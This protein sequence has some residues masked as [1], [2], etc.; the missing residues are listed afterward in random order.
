MVHGLRGKPALNRTDI[1]TEE[2]IVALYEGSYAGYNLT[3]FHQK[4][5]EAEH[6]DVSYPTVYYLLSGAG[7]RS[8]RAHRLRK[9]ESLHPLRKRRGAFG[10][11]VQM[12]ASIHPWI[13]DVAPHEKWALHLAI[14][15]AGSVVLAAH[16]EGQE[17]LR[18]YYRLFEKILLDYGC[19]EELYTDRRTVFASKST[20]SS[21][22]ED[23]AGT[24]FRMAAARL[25]VLEIHVSSVPQAKGR[26]ERAFQTFQD[27]LISEMRS[28][29]ITSIDGAN[30]FLPGFIADHNARYAQ[31]ISQLDNA[32]SAKPSQEE[33]TMALSVVCERMLNGGLAISYHG[34]HY[35]PFNSK[36]RVLIKAKT[37]VLVLHTLK[38]E[39]Y[40]VNGED[41]WP[42]VLMETMAM[43]TPED[44]KGKLNVPQKG[45]PW[46]EM[47]YQMMLKHLGKAS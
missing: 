27:R 18:G 12:D 11:L 21:R 35:A 44:L 10:E 37:K 26:V 1:S 6:I 9:C 25:G 47:S 38:D 22:L 2:R 17:T 7:Y 39:L 45:H 41:V 29:K 24:Q 32:F 31:D 46:K 4:L 43:P 16:F 20:T 19:P 15:D 36:E 42:L 30:A 34:K 28:A 5:C 40:M 14:D 33:I 8:P 13:P 3:H 23:D